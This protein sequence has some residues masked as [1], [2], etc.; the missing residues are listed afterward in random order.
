MVTQTRAVL[1]AY[2]AAGGHY[3]EVAL[4]AGHSPQIE[5]PE[6]FYAALAA[7]LAS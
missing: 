2:A 1:D 6:E 3:T 4:D 7:H 5:Q